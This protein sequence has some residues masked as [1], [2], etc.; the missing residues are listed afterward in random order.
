M[1]PWWLPLRQGTFAAIRPEKQHGDTGFDPATWAE[2]RKASSK[3]RGAR[4]ESRITL[5]HL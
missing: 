1:T 5:N 3:G 2:R 4:I